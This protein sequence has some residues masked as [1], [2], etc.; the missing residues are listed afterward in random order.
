MSG[1]DMS[2]DHDEPEY[3][4]LNRANWDERAPIHAES[5]MYAVHLFRDDP[6]HLSSTVRFDQPRLGDVAGL[7][8]VHLQC[9]IGTDTLSLHRLGARMSGLDFSAPSLDVARGLAADTGADIDY[10]LSDVGRAVDA[11]G[12]ERF[13]LVYTGIGAIGWLP[14]VGP[15]AEQVAGLLR[16]G[17]RLFMREGHPLMWTLDE[18]DPDR[19]Q[20][21]WDYFERYGPLV[22]EDAETYTDQSAPLT[23]VTTHEYNHG[24]GEVLAALL[25]AG[26][27]ITGVDEHE[28][29]PWL[30][31][32]GHMAAELDANEE[33]VLLPDRPRLPLT[34]T[35][36]AVKRSGVRR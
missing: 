9:H 33:Y 34:W 7:D 16:P 28:S 4:R 20:A 12:G 17:G 6:T 25:A 8:A 29:V 22:F 18:G 26:M 11:L 3:L 31:L 36:Q 21:R 14:E 1:S 10:V 27:E 32:P 2:T 35:V 13:D 24:M 30:A 19:L 15:W 23:Q 5:E